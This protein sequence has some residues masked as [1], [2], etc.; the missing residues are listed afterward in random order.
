VDAQLWMTR[1]QKKNRFDPDMNVAATR[2]SLQAA[3][4]TFVTA[5][6][7]LEEIDQFAFLQDAAV[8]LLVAY[9]SKIS[10]NK[11]KSGALELRECE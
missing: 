6:L 11:S 10:V 8:H 4:A 5:T 1:S 3:V 2:R 7:H 9:N